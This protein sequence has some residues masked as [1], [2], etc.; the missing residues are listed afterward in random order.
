MVF[1]FTFV[2]NDS[3]LIEIITAINNTSDLMFAKIMIMRKNLCLLLI[4]TWFCT[5]TLSAQTK[6]VLQTINDPFLQQLVKAKKDIHFDI[7]QSKQGAIVTFYEENKGSTSNQHSSII[8]ATTAASTNFHITKDINAQTDANPSNTDF[9][10]GYPFAVLN[11]VMYFSA[12]DGIH[13][14][15][16]WRSDG[17]ATGTYMVINLEP[18]TN[19][20]APSEIITAANKLYFV[21]ENNSL[22]SYKLWVS[23]GT[24]QG[25][26]MLKDFGSSGPGVNGS[27]DLTNVAGIVYFLSGSAYSTQVWKTNGTQ[28]STVEVK[29]LTNLGQSPTLTATA[30]GLYYFTLFSNTT[31]RELWRSD[32]TDDG[33]F[34]VKDISDTLDYFYGPYQ[35]TAFNNK[36]YFS[37][38]DG[39]GRKLWYTDGTSNGTN[40]VDRNSNLVLG[41]DYSFGFVKKPFA[42]LGNALFMAA[43]KP[44]TGNELYSY[45]T[46]TGF[47]LIKDIRPGST[48]GIIY[49]VTG[50]G[51]YV[52]FVY[53]DTVK[54][55]NQLWITTGSALGRSFLIKS[56]ANYTSTFDNLTP[57]GQQLYFTSNTPAA[58][59]ELWKTNG[60]S[61]GTVLIKDIFKGVTSSYPQFLTVFDSKLFFNAASKTS[62]TELWQTDGSTTN[63]RQLLEINSITT[64]YSGPNYYSKIAIGGNAGSSVNN[65]LF[66]SATT[67]E[68]GYELYKSD[69]TSAG[70]FLAKDITTG[71]EGSFPQMFTHKNKIVYFLTLGVSESGIYGLNIFKA[72]SIGNITLI[73]TEPGYIASYDVTDNGNVFYILY[74]SVT[75]K[76]E[77]WRSDGTQTGNFL[78]SNQVS[79]AAYPITVKTVHNKAYFT[80]ATDEEGTELWVSDGSLSGT[81]SMKDI[82]KGSGSS[83][84]YSLYP[85]N[86]YIYFGADDGSGVALWKSNGTTAG[87]IK[88]KT[89]QPYNTQFTGLNYNDFFR[90]VNNVLYFNATTPDKGAELWKTDGSNRGTVLVKDI[91]NGSDGSN[92]SYLT[93]VNDTL[94]FCVSNQQLWKS[95]GTSAGTMLIK[96]LN[97]SNYYA[98]NERCV[99]GNK[100]FFNKDQY[101]W[102]SDGTDVGTHMVAD[103]GLNGVSLISNLAAAG[104]T[105]FFNGY[106]DKYNYEMYAGDAAKV[107]TDKI[108]NITSQKKPPSFTA[109][110]LE[111]PV[112]SMLSLNI[113]SNKIQEIKIIIGNERGDIFISK[114]VD[115]N[116]GV[117]NIKIPVSNFMTGMY[118]VKLTNDSGDVVSLKALK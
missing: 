7:T 71:E 44:S 105:V 55:Q 109:S 115:V 42:I 52:A 81:K 94:F 13:G 95:N 69:G 67:P 17:T 104:N 53:E 3:I 33:T 28:F 11:N 47:S 15:E 112:R 106:S 32:G 82:L 16:L 38:D 59:N 64:S 76:P 25:T 18:G 26:S 114:S 58:G 102:V 6:H 19:S 60:T 73:P 35:L 113:K 65:T 86:N 89:L 88:I 80:A 36:L 77:L 39:N 75:G 22:V 49:N 50:A 110:I 24:A 72:D 12:D 9:I 99:A 83:N 51:K 87:T 1:K 45:D 31:G 30:A 116:K 48:G 43:T 85:F 34:M 29:D 63:T 90:S 100:F 10:D 103:N 91:I 37:D 92:P 41:D 5:L 66:F 93:D 8:N 79:P 97:S 23:N 117:N 84:P 118:A 74:N 101:L 62:G 54:K 14:S 96:N 68:T 2:C 57:A 20:S 21:T 70:T 78:L 98:F 111:N 61:K 46:L 40:E 56:Y 107:V 108:S 4:V 27:Y